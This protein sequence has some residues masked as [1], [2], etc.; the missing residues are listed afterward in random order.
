MTLSLLSALQTSFRG[1]E[2]TEQQIKIAAQNITNADRPGYTRKSF[3]PDYITGNFGTIPVGGTVVSALNKSLLEGVIDDKTV[4]GQKTVV[5]EYLENY[6]RRTG[7]VVSDFSLTSTLNDFFAHLDLLAI[8]PENRAQKEQIVSDAEVITLYLRDLSDGIQ[9]QRTE[10]EQEIDKTI[11]RINQSLATISNINDKIIRTTGKDDIALAEFEDVRA[12]ELQKLAEEIDITYYFD[13]RNRV[14]IYHPSGQPM[15]LHR[16][17]PLTFDPVATLT[18]TVTYPGGLNPIL[19]NGVS[20]VTQNL[21]GGKLAGLVELRD[22]SLVEEQEKLDE[23][24]VQLRDTINAVLNTGAARPPRNQLVGEQGFAGGDPFAGVGT[25]RIAVTDNSGIVQ[26]FTDLN[27]GGF[28]TVGAVVGAIN[29]L[30]GITASLSVSG[31][32]L[33][34]STDPTR[35][36]SI[37][38]MTSSVG[39]SNLGFSHYFGLNSMFTGIG[40]EDITISDYLLADSDYLALGQLSN[41]VTLAVGDTG[42][43]LG[44]VSVTRALSTALDTTVTFNAAGDFAAQNV[45]LRI[46]AESIMA[47]AA[48]KASIAQD[49]LDSAQIILQQEEDF[50]NNITGVNIDEET[51]ILLE[52]E[53]YYQASAQVIAVIKG[54]FEE[55]MAAVR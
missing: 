55:L 34:T 17:I 38:E 16:D 15:L 51:A 24:A 9:K 42:I 45:S 12:I 50:M 30:A 35:G 6:V 26:S 2:A 27:I 14:Q 11:D 47:R 28:G 49:E 5:A 19:A 3:Q 36:V 4:V 32:L 54:L 25:I 7:N 33:V 23:F 44:D 43:T 13:E 22:V 29:G 10:V 31:E 21:R 37:N 52:L 41:S 1:L 46:Y 39:G 40:A 8:A 18:G 20:D 53:S 48:L